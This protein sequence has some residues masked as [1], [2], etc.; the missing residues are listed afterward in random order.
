MIR[1]ITLAATPT[2]L[3]LLGFAAVACGG[4]S[5]GTT[6]TTDTPFP[7]SDTPLPPTNTP[8]SLTDTSV[9]ANDT[10]APPAGGPAS[11]GDINLQMELP[12]GDPLVGELTALP[13][14]CLG[15]HVDGGQD[16]REGPRFT[17]TDELPPIMDRGELRIGD[18]T[19]M[20]Q[21][22]TNW[23][24]VLESILLPEVYI[25]PGK[26]ADSTQMPTDFHLQLSET[27]LADIMAWLGTFE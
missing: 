19:Y 7:E 2:L 1:T 22:T 4:A 11:E 5:M 20:G 13:L 14:R 24:Y 8:P 23:E 12:A 10:P 26:W 27:D 15:C 9:P 21:A 16:D 6:V 3:F 18:P 17:S 25:V